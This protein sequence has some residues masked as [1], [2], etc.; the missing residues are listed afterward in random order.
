V[1]SYL[2]IRDAP[3]T[4]LGG[5]QML[6]LTEDTALDPEEVGR[7]WMES[8]AQPGTNAVSRLYLCPIGSVTIVDAT[9]ATVQ[10]VDVTTDIIPADEAF[11]D[12][13]PIP[14]GG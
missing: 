4:G 13:T 5:A 10:T 14:L 3:E 7:A 9:S 11:A 8:V 1:T 2:I 6:A 12:S